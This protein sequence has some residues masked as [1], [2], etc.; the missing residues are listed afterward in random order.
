[1]TASPRLFLVSSIVRDEGDADLMKLLKRLGDK[2]LA[3]GLLHHDPTGLLHA[4][5]FGMSI[6]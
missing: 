3:L 5:A 4:S 1:M 2:R 6:E